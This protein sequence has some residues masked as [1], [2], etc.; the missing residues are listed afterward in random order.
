MLKKFGL[1][2]TR[3]RGLNATLDSTI[4]EAFNKFLWFIK[5]SPENKKW[6]KK[7]ENQCFT[8]FCYFNASKLNLN[9]KKK[10]PVFTELKWY[11]CILLIELILF[12]YLFIVHYTCFR[13]HNIFYV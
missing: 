9:V 4:F 5:Y 6:K 12:E 8:H 2:N 3:M 10:V 7:C 13:K 1:K 11:Y